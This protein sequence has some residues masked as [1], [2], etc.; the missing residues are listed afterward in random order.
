MRILVAEDT[1]DNQFLIDVYLQGSSHV[2]TFV[3][4]GAAAVEQFR[5]AVFDLILMDVRMP[6]MD[7]LAATRAIRAIERERGAEAIPIIALTASARKEDIALSLQAGCSAHLSKPFSVDELWDAL[8]AFLPGPRQHAN[9]RD[10]RE[11]S[12]RGPLVVEMPEGF[13]ATCPDY[14][15]ARKRDCETIAQLI[16]AREFERI[17][18]LAH[19]MKGTGRSYGF[20]AL[21]ELGLAMETSAKAADLIALTSQLADLREYLSRVE[22]KAIAR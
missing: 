19:N 13:E 7:G 12:P 11:A 1:P 22:L 10:H 21:T 3:E 20:D 16:E 17:R 2:L 4:D 15:C 6:R 5:D 9:G 14:L 8:Q 18:V